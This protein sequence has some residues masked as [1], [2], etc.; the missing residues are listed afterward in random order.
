MGVE[1]SCHECKCEE[2]CPT[3]SGS[4]T[5]MMPFTFEEE[6]CNPGEKCKS[7]AAASTKSI[8]LLQQKSAIALTEPRQRKIGRTSSSKGRKGIDDEKRLHFSFRYGDYVG[9]Q[10]EEITNEIARLTLASLLV[11]VQ[12]D[13][14]SAFARTKDGQCGLCAGDVI[15]E[16]NGRRGTAA[17]IRKELEE[18]VNYTACK[19][20]T[21]VVRPRPAAFYV[22]IPCSEADAYRKKLGMTAVM[23]K[24]SSDCILVQALRSEG[25]VPDWNATHGSL[26]IVAGDLIVEVNGISQDAPAMC[27]AMQDLQKSSSL[28]FRIMTARSHESQQECTSC[29]DQVEEPTDI[30]FKTSQ[31]ASTP[32]SSR[33]SEPM[34][35]AFEYPESGL[36]ARSAHDSTQASPGNRSSRSVSITPSKV[37]PSKLTPSKRKKSKRKNAMDSDSGEEVE[38]SVF[39]G[40]PSKHWQGS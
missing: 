24:S 32:C 12:V 16:V 40:T 10:L 28:R 23:D 31:Q 9:L 26:Q 34:D 19:G 22:E 27:R 25:L 14:A 15:V 6:L 38:I 37:T 17:Q 13:A 18:E 8:P 3:P 36:V 11:V 4:P 29:L 21:L 30:V 5:K 35:I 20:I 39:L 2:K 1:T 33:W 7:W